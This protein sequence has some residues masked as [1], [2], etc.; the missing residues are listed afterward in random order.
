MT[1][2]ISL[3]INSLQ[4]AYKNKSLSPEDI[5]NAIYDKIKLYEDYNIWI[6]VVSKQEVLNKIQKLKD[7]SKTRELPLYCIPFAVKDNIDVEEMPTTAACREY[8]YFPNKSAKVVKFLEEAGAILIGKTN[9]DQFATGLVGTRSPYGAVKNSYNSEYISGGSSSGSAVSVAL[10]MVSFSLGTDTA[11]SGRVPAGFNNL[12]G[13]KPTKGLICTDGVV[14]ACKSLDCVSV[15]SLNSKDAAHILEI[16]SEKTE[17]EVILKTFKQTDGFSF[18]V[19][20]KEHLVFYGN[21]ENETI[22][23]NFIENLKQLGGTMKEVDFNVFKETAK[24]LYQGPW[25]AERLASIENFFSNN[26]DC[27]L[28]EIKSIIELGKNYSAVDTFKA[29]YQ[30]EEYKKIANAYFKKNDYLVV[31]TAPTIYTIREVLEN[32]FELNTQLGYYTNF[33]NLLNLC[34]LSI[35]AGIQKNGIPMGVTIISSAH[36]DYLLLALGELFNRKQYINEKT[37]I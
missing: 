9:L 20:K 10:G 18:M 22:F 25:V 7:L 19:P 1:N 21:T 37:T 31:P 16:V 34:A 27:L 23:Y 32:P 2:D 13:Y 26:S 14:P 30:L 36:N 11:G 12:F 8:E 28:H 17:E 6:H 35:P 3:D 15:F 4:T 29:M 24:L 5:V 33:V